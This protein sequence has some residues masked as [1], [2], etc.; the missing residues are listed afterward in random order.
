MMALSE[1]M[2]ELQAAMDFYGDTTGRLYMISHKFG[3]EITYTLAEYLGEGARVLGVPPEGEWTHQK[4]EHRDAKYSTYRSGYLRIE[5]ILMGVAIKIPHSKDSGAYWIRVT[6]E[7]V[8]VG[9]TI[10]VHVGEKSL[11]GIPVEY[12]KND[13]ERVHEM[14]F[15]CA[16]NTM[17]HPASEATS[18]GSGRIGFIADEN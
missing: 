12:S 7:M 14:I 13:V 5:P 2:L 18:K 15:E 4:G 17:L 16:R 3:D 10:T 8:L 1:R 9:D 6:I 11:R